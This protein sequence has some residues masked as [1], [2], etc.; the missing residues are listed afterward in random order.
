MAKSKLAHELPVP[1]ICSYVKE[2]MKAAGLQ[3]R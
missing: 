3:I 2:L 1:L